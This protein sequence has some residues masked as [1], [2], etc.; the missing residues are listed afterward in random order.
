MPRLRSL[1]L[2]AREILVLK[3]TNT[4]QFIISLI[5]LILAL[6]GDEKLT[7]SLTIGTI[8]CPALSMA[9]AL[10]G[11]VILFVVIREDNADSRKWG[12]RLFLFYIVT[13]VI[14]CVVACLFTAG[15]TGALLGLEIVQILLLL[16]G[17]MCSLRIY[18]DVYHV[19][20]MIAQILNVGLYLLGA[21]VLVIGVVFAKANVDAN[22]ETGVPQ[23]AL[24]MFAV[25]GGGIALLACL[26]FFGIT[27][28]NKYLMCVYEVLMLVVFVGLLITGAVVSKWDIKT[29]VSGSCS[30]LMRAADIAFWAERFGCDKYV[31]FTISNPVVTPFPLCTPK[32]DLAV[33]YE[34][35]LRPYPTACLNRQCCDGITTYVLGSA[36]EIYALGLALFLIVIFL[37]VTTY[38]FIV[39]DVQNECS[40]GD[41]GY[42]ASKDKDLLYLTTYKSKHPEDTAYFFVM[43]LI[44]VILV[45]VLG[46]QLSSISTVQELVVPPNTWVTG[47]VSVVVDLGISGCATLTN[48]SSTVNA[49]MANGTSLM[50]L[51]TLTIGRGLWQWNESV[52]TS[53]NISTSLLRLGVGSSANF[54]GDLQNLADFVGTLQYC[55]LCVSETVP[56]EMSVR[57]VSNMTAVQTVTSN[58]TVQSSFA[59]SFSGLVLARLNTTDSVVLSG[60]TITTV[61]RYGC[62]A[63]RANA[64]SD[65]SG[66]YNLNF[67]V[68]GLGGELVTF[69]YSRN[70]YLPTTQPV[71]DVPVSQGMFNMPVVYMYQVPS[72]SCP[73]PC[74][75]NVTCVNTVVEP[76]YFCGSCPSGYVGDGI[77][78]TDVDECLAHPCDPLTNC[79]NLN[80]SY[81][82]SA[83]PSGYSGNGKAGCNDINECLPVDPCDSHS[84]CINFRGGYSCAPCASGYTGNGFN[85][86]DI[87]ECLPTNPCSSLSTCTNLDGSYNCSACPQGYQGSGYTNCSD[88]NE[89][90]VASNCPT[91]STCQNLAPGFNCSCNPGT[92][93]VGNFSGPFPANISCQDCA[94]PFCQAYAS[95]GAPCHCTSCQPG[96]YPNG[97]NCTACDP[98]V[99]PAGSA[100]VG[101]GQASNGTCQYVACP[102][103]S[104]GPDITSCT[105]SPGY[106]G[107]ITP[108][109][110]A[111]NYYSGS[112]SACN[113]GNCSSYSSGCS[114]S[115]CAANTSSYASGGVCVDCIDSCTGGQFLSGCGGS[116]NGTCANCPISPCV[117]FGALCTCTLCASNYYVNTSN[118]CELCGT[119]PPGKVRTNCALGPGTCEE[120]TCPA[121]STGNVS[122]TCQCLPGYAGNI[123]A[124]TTAPYYN[125][126][127]DDINECL[128]ANNSC[129]LQQQLC[130]N[131]IGN[132]SCHDCDPFFVSLDGFACVDKNECLHCTNQTSNDPLVCPC[133]YMT[134]CT[135]LAPAYQCGDCPPGFRGRSDSAGGEGA[136]GC[137]DIDECAE[138]YCYGPFGAPI[139][140]NTRGSFTCSCAP[141][142]NLTGGGEEYGGAFE[143]VDIN[144]C[145]VGNG[146]CDLLTTCTNTIG[147]FYCGQCP[148]G[149]SGNGSGIG[150]QDVNECQP[151]SPCAPNASCINVDLKAANLTRTSCVCD[152]GDCAFIASPI[153][154]GSGGKYV[155]Q[156]YGRYTTRNFNAMICDQ[157]T[158]QLSGSFSIQLSSDIRSM[159]LACG[160]TVRWLLKNLNGTTVYRSAAMASRTSP[161]EIAFEYPSCV[162]NLNCSEVL[163]CDS[164]GLCNILP[165]SCFGTNNSQIL[166]DYAVISAACPANGQMTVVRCASVNGQECFTIS[167]ASPFSLNGQYLCKVGGTASC[168]EYSNT[169]GDTIIMSATFPPTSNDCTD[170]FWWSLSDGAVNTT[171]VV[172]DPTLGPSNGSFPVNTF[173]QCTFAYRCGSCPSGYDGSAYTSCT[174]IDECQINHG[175]CDPYASCINTPGSYYCGNCTT[176]YS[177]PP[178]VLNSNLGTMRITIRNSHTGQIAAPGR[179]D[180]YNGFNAKW[181]VTPPTPAVTQTVTTTG[182]AVISI[183]EGS[184]TVMS[185][186]TPTPIPPYPNHGIGT[187]NVN[188][189]RGQ[190]F[191]LT[192]YYVPSSILTNS[193]S[194]AIVLS[195]QSKDSGSANVDLDLV[196]TKYSPATYN[197][198]L[199]CCQAYALVGPCGAVQVMYDS[200]SANGVEEAYLSSSEQV[201]FGGLYYSYLV[202]ARW[203]PSGDSSQLKKSN[204]QIRVFSGLSGKW[205]EAA[206]DLTFSPAQLANTTFLPTYW[207]AFCLQRDSSGVIT[208]KDL[209]NS[210]TSAF[211]TSVP[212]AAQYCT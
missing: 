170:T 133:D 162:T 129:V 63:S 77:N 113:V 41:P 165:N 12:H 47:N 89:C 144:E 184:Y 159:K 182:T 35:S 39:R 46:V 28:A 115:S 31:G 130:L 198:S 2:F 16:A 111:P 163:G 189:A 29:E 43:L 178:C 175:G 48:L 67:S 193:D 210:T 70:S 172:A 201:S 100:L 101:C 66:Q 54:T 6:T 96:Y 204:A 197:C 208:Y 55:P 98:A 107:T 199:P 56:F 131:T 154:P 110:T 146:G 5:L 211:S 13:A 11:G 42:D 143:C 191:F 156:H 137:E 190:D 81:S 108:T 19:L 167:G 123:T 93:S 53:M 64:T 125:G 83:C 90:L 76:G 57:P 25:L 99:C 118:H 20:H 21:L 136:F 36:N 24:V 180:V 44:L 124:T 132:Y 202:Y 33:V 18:E 50:A 23:T 104:S 166:T 119:C 153:Y 109:K 148:L 38:L 59:Q 87:N 82:C 135:N 30:D 85:C 149:Y 40:P 73:S 173:A 187:Q 22:F 164:T 169:E 86:T 68:S 26:G 71:S 62:P 161:S 79:T 122:T 157:Y 112:C 195:W 4:L 181:A 94:V 200:T 186:Y 151:T 177:G 49:S 185:L 168:F 91:S 60:V 179:V 194:R 127:C 117:T 97:T 3:I 61:D 176:G 32:T 14:L 203:T 88:I 84:Y 1:R 17:I 95:A 37:I 183:P 27:R 196:V 140:N 206:Y 141:G 128:I 51:M 102:A 72:L 58:V 52:A 150:C 171:V 139:C 45:I 207:P 7:T 75:P 15:S 103:H 205:P 126:S 152:G 34:S 65:A 142:Y 174:D 120:V 80:G 10:Y 160:A 158:Q 212:T 116:S 92:F 8:V 145:L 192:M 9:I 138:G 74:Y 155:C 106:T 134:N 147:G 209:R 188:F 114:C 69:A 121:H 105:C 78:C